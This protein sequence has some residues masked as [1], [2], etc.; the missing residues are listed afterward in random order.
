MSHFTICTRL[1]LTKRYWCEENKYENTQHAWQSQYTQNMKETSHLQAS[2]VDGTI[3]FNM[4]FTETWCNNVL[5]WAVV[6]T[7]MIRLEPHRHLEG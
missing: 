7:V 3:I 2:G 1:L 5:W 6:H 4:W